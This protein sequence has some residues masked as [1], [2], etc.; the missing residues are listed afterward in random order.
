MSIGSPGLL[1]PTA[2]E[3]KTKDFNQVKYVKDEAGHL[4]MEDDGIRHRQ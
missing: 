3:G 2:Y 1:L 4:S